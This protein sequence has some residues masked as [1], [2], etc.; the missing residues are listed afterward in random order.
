MIK[1]YATI[2]EKN[3]EIYFNHIGLNPKYAHFYGVN[4]KNKIYEIVLEP[5]EDQS[6]PDWNALEYW[7]W[8][9]YEDNEYKMIW[10]NYRLFHCCFAYGVKAEENSG[11][12]KAVRLKLV[13]YEKYNQMD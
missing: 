13:S 4:D 10:P 2:E 8:L 1:E 6:E 5:H 7:G 12:G 9:D 3:N 11:R